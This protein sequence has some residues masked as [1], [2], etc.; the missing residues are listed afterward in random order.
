LIRCTRVQQGVSDLN[1]HADFVYEGI[2][3]Y[4]PHYRTVSST[5][6]RFVLDQKAM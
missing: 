2:S 3:V 1:I 4:S 5:V 6:L